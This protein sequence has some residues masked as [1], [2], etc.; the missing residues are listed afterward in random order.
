MREIKVGLLVLAALAA[1]ALGIFMVGEKSSLFVRKNR[2]F[3]RFESVEGLA[4][5]NPVQL[6]GV[7]VG[8]VD[9]IILPERVEQEQLTVWVTVN[10]RYAGRVRMDSQAGIKTLGLLGDK[11]I[12]LQSGSPESAAIPDGGE[13]P[14]APR[15]ELDELIASGGSAMDNLVAISASLRTILGKMERGEGVLGELTT[16]SETGREAKERIL[17]ILASAERISGRLEEGRGPLGTLLAD[18]Q[19]ASDLKSSVQRL[20]ATLD[21]LESGEGIAPALLSDAALRQRFDETLANLQTASQ[22]MSALATDLEQGEGLLARLIADEQYGAEVAEELKSLVH[23]LNSVSGKLERGEGS[24]GA[25][26]NDPQVYQALNDVIIG[27]NESRL[28]RWLVRNRQEAGFKK[29]QRE[30]QSQEDPGGE[31]P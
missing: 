23:N 16:D 17:G 12:Q 21:K 9:D 31:R 19:L 25:M 2:Y 30:A 20:T 22:S 7:N 27:I 24:L 18:E 26:I 3:V 6:N 1:L 8:Q 14:S 5:G 10:R 13:I 11:Y 28:L 4:V 15:T 29:R